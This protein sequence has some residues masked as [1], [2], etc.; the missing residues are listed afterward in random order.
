VAKVKSIL[1]C[2]VATNYCIAL[3]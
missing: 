2:V 3:W 1:F